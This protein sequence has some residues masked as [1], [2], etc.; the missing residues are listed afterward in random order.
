VIFADD[1]VLLAKEAV[2]LQGVIER[3]KLE[4]IMEWK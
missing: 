3:L 2:V 1:V 4:D